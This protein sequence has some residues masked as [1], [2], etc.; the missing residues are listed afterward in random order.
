M[1]LQIFGENIPERPDQERDAL[2]PL[3][4]LMLSNAKYHPHML[5]V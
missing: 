5:D 2:P 3:D 4:M 1:A